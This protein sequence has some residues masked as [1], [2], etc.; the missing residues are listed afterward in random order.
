[1]QPSEQIVIMA[2]DKTLENGIPNMI[3][4]IFLF[5]LI[6]IRVSPGLPVRYKV[7]CY[8]NSMYV[9]LMFSLTQ[10]DGIL[11]MIRYQKLYFAF[12]YATKLYGI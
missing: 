9:C 11:N 10:F 2:L 7:V 4:V 1:M 3:I 12:Q 8:L 5:L 6:I